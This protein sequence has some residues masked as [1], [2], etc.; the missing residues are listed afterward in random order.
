M[1]TWTRNDPPRTATY[2]VAASD[3]P[4]HV[5][6]Q[7]DYVCDGTADEARLNE[8]IALL[9]SGGSVCVMLG[10][11]HATAPV[12]LLSNVHIIFE[13]GAIWNY[14]AVDGTNAFQVNAAYKSNITIS[15]R[16]KIVGNALAGTGIL[17]KWVD[18]LV[19]R[20]VEVTGFTKAS[21]FGIDIYGTAAYKT[22]KVYDTYVHD[23]AEG[24]ELYDIDECDVAGNWV[25]DNP[26]P[27]T[28]GFYGGIRL[29]EVNKSK[30]R[31]NFVLSTGATEDQYR[32]ITLYEICDD[33]E[34]INNVVNCGDVAI[35]IYTN[36]D[37]NIVRGNIIYKIRT[38]NIQGIEVTVTSHNNLI[39]GNIITGVGGN[40]ITIGTGCNTNILGTNKAAAIVDA[41]TGTISYP[42]ITKVW[43]AHD[44]Q[45]PAIGTVYA[46]SFVEVDV[47][48]NE[49]FNSDGTDLLTIGYDAD[50]DSIMTSLDISTTG[51]K[52]ITYGVEGGYMG[53]S[54]AIEAY[55]TAGSSAP[56]TGHALIILKVTNVPTP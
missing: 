49:A 42:A 31:D 8:A 48:V 39:E 47:W 14:D 15:G 40:D 20:D 12:N 50:P 28:E 3:A 16:G 13:Q 29:H 17:M 35:E 24:I 36:S 34:I 37:R 55:Y 51:R 38:G 10:N 18:K 52:A 26:P 4:A 46:R 22:A 19:I 11:Y 6:T 33:N 56:T 32:G 45:N 5:K 30:I 27:G 7:A 44:A 23:N 9:T 53:T 25:V 54:R 43:V 2:V 1:A 41:G 21:N